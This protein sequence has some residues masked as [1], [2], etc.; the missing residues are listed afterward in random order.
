MA[1]KWLPENTNILLIQGRTWLV[2]PFHFHGI[3][4]K[5]EVCDQ[6]ISQIQLVLWR[7]M[8]SISGLCCTL[9]TS[10]TIWSVDCRSL[11]YGHQ[12]FAWTSGFLSNLLVSRAITRKLSE[13]AIIFLQKD[14]HK[15]ELTI[16][17]SRTGSLRIHQIH[18]LLLISQQL[19][20]GN[21]NKHDV[22]DSNWSQ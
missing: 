19:K 2:W 16:M 13:H 21:I 12:K 11:Y 22:S 10:N 6:H 5:P 7:R 3:I 1:V 18:S 4:V 17:K 20:R 15:E 14:Q 8:F 9:C